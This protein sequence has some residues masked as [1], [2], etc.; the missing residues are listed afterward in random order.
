MSKRAKKSHNVF[1]SVKSPST[2]TDETVNEVE[3]ALEVTISDVVEKPSRTGRSSSVMSMEK[4][5]QECGGNSLQLD[6]LNE[7]ESFPDVDTLFSI[8]AGHKTATRKRVLSAAAVLSEQNETER[9]GRGKKAAPKVSTN[10]LLLGSPSQKMG[11]KSIQSPKKS[12]VRSPLRVG[13]KNAKK[14]KASMSNSNVETQQNVMNLAEVL[15]ADSNIIP[16]ALSLETVV[17]SKALSQA[18]SQGKSYGGARAGS[19]RR[20]KTKSNEEVDLVVKKVTESTKENEALAR[21]SY[22]ISVSQV[23]QFSTNH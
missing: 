21:M 7:D 8:G 5:I 22:V 23:Q 14:V 2:S 12:K 20:K 4:A 18:K 16:D 19:G 10:A 13:T 17:P 3:K 15:V 6:M 1:N 9:K 11:F